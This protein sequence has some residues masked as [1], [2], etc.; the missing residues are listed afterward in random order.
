M[1]K[2]LSIRA[3]GIQQ[4]RRRLFRGAEFLS[5]PRPAL[6]IVAD[7]VL[8]SIGA[9]F[10]SQGRRYGGSWRAISP[11]WL[12]WKIDH[13]KDPRILHMNGT[14]RAAFSERGAEHQ[15]LNVTMTGISLRS[16]LKYDRRQNEARPFVNFYPQDQK[17]WVAIMEQEMKAALGF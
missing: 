7:D 5:D 4:V 1:A 14:L 12:K 9:T 10:S 3:L 17:R 16:D 15:I 2:I 8:R 6:E 11:K 13:G